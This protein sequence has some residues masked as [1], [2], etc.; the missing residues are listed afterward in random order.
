MPKYTPEQ[1]ISAFW[2]KVDKSGGADAC[3]IWTRNLNADGYGSAH[4][5]SGKSIGAHRLAWIYT[6][7]DIPQGLQV[8]HN[9]PN[10]DN[11]SCCNPAHL[12]LG[13]IADNAADRER[14][15]RR[16]APRG[17]NHAS[18]KYSD[19]VIAAV[20]Q[21]RE[22]HG[23]TE[24]KLAEQFGMSPSYVHLIINQRYRT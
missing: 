1:A 17:M 15:G 4:T 18:T 10:G 13:T 12:W 7:G 24:H 14:K 22:L 5:L 3:W 6:N 2:S 23:T 16:K 11:P 19:E 8:L 21:E 9:C 20:R